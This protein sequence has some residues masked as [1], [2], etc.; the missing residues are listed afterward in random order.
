MLWLWWIYFCPVQLHWSLI[1]AQSQQYPFDVG[2]GGRE[3][4]YGEGMRTAAT[5]AS[6][7]FGGMTKL[8]FA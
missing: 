5:C 3:L 6:H 7:I 8:M 1:R 4:D 2:A